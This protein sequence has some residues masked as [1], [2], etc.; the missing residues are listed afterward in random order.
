MEHVSDTSVGPVRFHHD[1]RLL[2]PTPLY[3]SLEQVFCSYLFPVISQVAS[4]IEAIK[5]RAL[6]LTAGKGW[7][8]PPHDVKQYVEIMV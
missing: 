6:L 1:P 8:H 3:F 5:C 2:I 7:P 4:Y